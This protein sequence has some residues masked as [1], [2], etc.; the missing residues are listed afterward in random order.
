MS[1]EDLR[2][3]LAIARH[4]TLTGAAGALGVTHTPWSSSGPPR[5]PERE[6]VHAVCAPMHIGQEGGM[7]GTSGAMAPVR[8]QGT[9][10]PGERLHGQT[11][12]YVDIT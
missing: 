12:I 9:G 1:W 3:V 5:R 6:R 8:A 4:G 2:G 7:E 11:Y 10:K